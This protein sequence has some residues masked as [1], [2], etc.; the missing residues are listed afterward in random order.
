MAFLLAPRGLVITRPGD[1]RNG[2]KELPPTVDTD[3]LPPGPL[4][5]GSARE[6]KH[7]AA[8]IRRLSDWRKFMD[9]LESHLRVRHAQSSS[10]TLGM[11][12][13]QFY[14]QTHSMLTMFPRRLRAS[15]FVEFRGRR[16]LD[17]DSVDQQQL[18]LYVTRGEMHKSR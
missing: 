11:A 12:P 4:S 17:I 3:V 1:L 18:A 5:P 16:H 8:G 2:A 10:P 9:I 15:Q 6:I 13:S 7:I 14:L